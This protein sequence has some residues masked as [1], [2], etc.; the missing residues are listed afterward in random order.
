[1]QLFGKNTTN[2]ITIKNNF[3]GCVW[4]DF[5]YRESISDTRNKNIYEGRKGERKKGWPSQNIL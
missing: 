1:V 3:V 4:L 5:L 2:I